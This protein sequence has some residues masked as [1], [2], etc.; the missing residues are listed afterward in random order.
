M[1]HTA[2]DWEITVDVIM[3]EQLVIAESS[4]SAEKCD[5]VRRL[6]EDKGFEFGVCLCV[7]CVLCQWC[8]RTL[9]VGTITALGQSDVGD[10]MDPNEVLLGH[11]PLGVS[12][13]FGTSRFGCTATPHATPSPSYKKSFARCPF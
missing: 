10:R 2:R 3:V 4:G 12:A 11:V 13:S 7:D 9:A 1:D 5:L 6:L 8:V